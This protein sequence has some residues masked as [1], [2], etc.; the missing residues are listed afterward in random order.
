MSHAKTFQPLG[1]GQASRKAQGQG[2]F[3][4]SCE[5]FAKYD[6]ATSSWKTCQLSLLPGVD[7]TPYSERWPRQGLMLSGHVFQRQMWA[8]AIGVIGGGVL[9]TPA[10]TEWKGATR[11]RF[12]GSPHYKGTRTSEALRTC[13]EDPT[14]LHPDYAEALMGY[15]AGWT[16][17]EP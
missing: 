4:N 2:F 14:V 1:S 15:P 16:V 13:A 7:L 17:C 12:R 6:L 3:M 11:Q 5:W 10:A 8:P 9:P